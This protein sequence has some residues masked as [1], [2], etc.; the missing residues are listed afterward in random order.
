METLE[1]R[2]KR[3]EGLKLRPYYDNAKPPKLTIGYGRCL[4]THPLSPAEIAYIGHDGRKLPI[5][6]DQAQWLLE[7][8]IGACE[9]SVAVTFPWAASMTQTR[10]DVLVEMV[11][12]MGMATL[13]KFVH[14]LSAM[15]A[16]DYDDAAADMLDS[17]WH[18]QT[19]G[20]A[21]E[22]ADLMKNG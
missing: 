16:G 3:H 12:Q 6:P 1:E 11:F 22:L 20:R 8:D 19:P 2:I 10:Q 5:T 21:E 14:T 13:L 4:D 17:A 15:K 9:R 7:R 18:A